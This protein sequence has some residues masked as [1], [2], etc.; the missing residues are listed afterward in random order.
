MK[1][2]RRPQARRVEDGFREAELGPDVLHADVF[3][4]SLVV[5]VRD[6]KKARN[7]L[8]AQSWG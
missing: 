6:A 2:P 1:N 4:S 8:S 7:S 5:G 3:Q